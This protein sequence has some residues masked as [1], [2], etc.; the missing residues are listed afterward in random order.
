MALGAA[1][2]VT[3][4]LVS[5]LFLWQPWRSCSYDDRPSA[6]TM[7]PA[8]A[9]VLMVSAIST[10]AGVTVLVM[11]WLSAQEPRSMPVSRR[12]TVFG[13]VPLCLVAVAGVLYLV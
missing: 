9:A 3:G 5:A 7:L 1:T 6:C 2:S 12:A 10:L 8:D 11:A 13:A 4:A